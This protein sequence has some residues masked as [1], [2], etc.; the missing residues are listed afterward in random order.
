[1]AAQRTKV[2]NWCEVHAKIPSLVSRCPH[3]TTI[4]YFKSC[5]VLGMMK[6]GE[7]HT[8]SP[9]LADYL[10]SVVSLVSE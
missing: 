7:K 2:F 6:D 4:I 8:I 5:Q 9:K 3:W 1:M 10:C